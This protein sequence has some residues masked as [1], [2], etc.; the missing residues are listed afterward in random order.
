MFVNIYKESGGAEFGWHWNPA[1]GHSG[2]ILLGVRQDFLKIEGRDKG[3][4][5]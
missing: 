1:Q 5:L 4:S 2:G 3:G